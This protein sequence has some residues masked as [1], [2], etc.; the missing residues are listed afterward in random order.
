MAVVRP[1]N[2]IEIPNAH[3]EL[4][5]WSAINMGAKGVEEIGEIKVFPALSFRWCAGS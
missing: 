4:S 1:V 5:A 3:A 2:H